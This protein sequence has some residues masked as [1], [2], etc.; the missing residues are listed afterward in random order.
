MAIFQVMET[1]PHAAGRVA[2]LEGN[3]TRVIRGK[4]E[5]VRLA[6]I[7]LLSRG[8]LLLED[9]PGV[10]K[11]TLAHSLAN[12]LGLSF[13]RIQ[14]TSDL[15]PSDILGVSVYHPENGE[16]LFR[17]GPLFA[18]IV[19]ADEIN[20]TT[21]KTQSAF[22]EAMSDARV[23]VDRTTHRLPSPFM[24]VATQNPLEFEGTYPLPESQMDRFTM[25]LAMGYPD[26]DSEA[27]LYTAGRI[28]DPARDLTPVMSGEEVESL[29]SRAEAARVAAPIIDYLVRI[30]EAS[31][32][33]PRISLGVSPRGGMTLLAAARARAMV[34]GRDFVVPD[35]V[36]ALAVPVLAHRLVLDQRAGG[37]G[38]RREDAEAVIDEILDATPV[39]L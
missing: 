19:L 33:H 11:T 8:H 10:G 35:D 30:V 27:S 2:D 4:Q 14:F 21:P 3:I 39:P 34:E 5:V 16:F 29:Q 17:P 15:F 28:A 18:H 36:K 23:T 38:R 22:L 7:T 32:S 26:R 25:R 12:S 6:V 37:F 31:R 24:V 9:V 13:K 20:R 1:L